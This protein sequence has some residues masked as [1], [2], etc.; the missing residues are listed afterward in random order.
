MVCEWIFLLWSTLNA[1]SEYMCIMGGENL[2]EFLTKHG[3]KLSEKEAEDFV[4]TCVPGDNKIDIE[5]NHSNRRRLTNDMN[6]LE[7]CCL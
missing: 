1:D 7:P 2:I 5:S 4:K 3:D 6:V